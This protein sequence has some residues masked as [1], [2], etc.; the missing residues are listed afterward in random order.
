M[1]ATDADMCALGRLRVTKSY[2]LEVTRV[3]K[4][5]DLLQ[6]ETD[7]QVIEINAEAARERAIIEG[8]ANAHALQHEQGAR[9]TMYK[10]LR[11]HL[12]WSAEHFL[13]YIKMKALNA[14]PNN[15]VVVGVN[16]LG[17]VAS[18]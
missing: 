8:R 12:G 5:V 1:L 14:Q 13:Q 11:D 18:A 7:A 3:V 15:N 9:S 6:S 16:A 4:E 17:S 10:R 2:Q